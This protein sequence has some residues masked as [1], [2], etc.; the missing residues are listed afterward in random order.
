MFSIVC[1]QGR[2]YVMNSC[3]ISFLSLFNLFL[4]K[5]SFFL[6]KNSL[7]RLGYA[8]ITNI[9]LDLSGCSNTS[10]VGRIMIPPP[11]APPRCLCSNPPNLLHM[12]S[13]KREFPCLIKL[14]LLRRDDYPG[15]SEKVQYN[16]D[17]SYKTAA[18]R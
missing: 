10:F 1:F 8:A 3:Y 17:S 14:R 6:K 13:F 7:N 2:E 9:P 11:T 18:G 12:L 4:E 15:L 5:N 16:P